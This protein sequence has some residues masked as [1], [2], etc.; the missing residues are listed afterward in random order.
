ML[1]GPLRKPW[2]LGITITTIIITVIIGIIIN[3]ITK[4][5]SH[6]I[7]CVPS[8][9]HQNNPQHMDRRQPLTL[10]P[11]SAEI[12]HSSCFEDVQV[13]GSP[14]PTQHRDKGKNGQ[15]GGLSV[16]VKPAGPKARQPRLNRHGPA[17][18]GT[19]GFGPDASWLKQWQLS[20]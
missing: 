15:P 2:V 4:A 6:F 19:A 8:M 5:S 14:L 3:I 12:P 7:R 10:L 13:P 17:R 9:E 16:P 11:A 20:F 1:L 18:G